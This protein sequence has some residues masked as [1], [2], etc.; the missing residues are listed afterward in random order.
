[1]Q[2]FR[3][4]LGLVFVLAVEVAGVVFVLE[5]R[6]AEVEVPHFVFAEVV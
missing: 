6:V 2:C 1:M 5:W 3:V 4:V